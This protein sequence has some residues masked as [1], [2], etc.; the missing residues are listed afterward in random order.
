[1]SLLATDPKKTNLNLANSLE[2]NFSLAKIDTSLALPKVAKSEE[3]K[4][5]FVAQHAADLK[6]D[7]KKLLAETKS[8]NI[9]TNKDAALSLL[10]DK[11]KALSIVNNFYTRMYSKKFLNV[12]IF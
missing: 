5:V 1:M 9:G 3:S 6:N 12:K 2:S 8:E 4:I 10:K 11:V 7:V